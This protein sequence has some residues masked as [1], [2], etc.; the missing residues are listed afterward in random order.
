ME[1]EYWTSISAMMR[2]RERVTGKCVKMAALFIFAVYLF[3]FFFIVNLNTNVIVIRNRIANI[4]EAHES[5]FEVD[6][7]LGLE[8]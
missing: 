7:D 3:L 4:N 1:L 5:C 2:L 6:I 8:I